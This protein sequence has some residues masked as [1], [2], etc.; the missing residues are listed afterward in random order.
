MPIMLKALSVALLDY[1]VLNSSLSEDGSEITY[2]AAHNIGVAMDTP[3]G[4]V[5]PNIKGCERLR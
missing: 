2:H 1:P 3:R 5:V 4:L